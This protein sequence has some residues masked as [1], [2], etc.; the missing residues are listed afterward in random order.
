MA[1]RRSGCDLSNGVTITMSQT[2]VSVAQE[3]TPTNI[4]A[5][6]PAERPSGAVWCHH[7]VPSPNTVAIPV[8]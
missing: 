6:G 5:A 4:H 1:E 2:A 8:T 7:T 3:R